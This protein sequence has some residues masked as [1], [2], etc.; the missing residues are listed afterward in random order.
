M[1]MKV[2]FRSVLDRILLALGVN[3]LNFSGTIKGV[4][5]IAADPHRL[6]YECSISL[7]IMKQL[8]TA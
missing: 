7:I 1:L 6:S 4:V 3:G 2:G 8:L 5:V